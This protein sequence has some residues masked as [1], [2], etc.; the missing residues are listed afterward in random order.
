MKMH[1][2]D[3]E[4]LI[5]SVLRR[6]PEGNDKHAAEMIVDAIIKVEVRGLDDLQTR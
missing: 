2:K 3:L 4:E 5:Y 1:D 6:C